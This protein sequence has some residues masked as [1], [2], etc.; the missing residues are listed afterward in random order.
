MGRRPVP[1]TPFFSLRETRDHGHVLRAARIFG[2]V[3]A[4][5][6]AQTGS[7]PARADAQSPLVLSQYANLTLQQRPEKGHPFLIFHKPRSTW[8]T[9]KFNVCGE[10]LSC[11]R[12]VQNQGWLL[13]C[14][15]P[16]QDV[17][18]QDDFVSLFGDMRSDED[19][20]PF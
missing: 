8:V 11:S 19:L 4:G 15:S 9:S 20:D 5:V 7:R 10:Y 6:L 16:T 1:C 3:T 13:V 14:T 17:E 2:R 12:K 18:D